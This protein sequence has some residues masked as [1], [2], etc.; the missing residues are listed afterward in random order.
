[1]QNEDLCFIDPRRND[2]FSSLKGLDLQELIVQ[3]ENFY[4]IYREKLNLP[5]YVTLGM[6]IEYEGVSKSQVDK[7]I[8]NNLPCWNS[9]I[10]GS[11]NSGGEIQSPVL[12]DEPKVWEDLQKI[13]EFLKENKADT[14]HNAGGHIHIGAHVLGDNPETW[15]KFLKLYIAYESVLFRFLYGDKISGRKKMLKYAEPMADKLFSRL[16]KIKSISS[17]HEMD[18][19]LPGDK[20]QAINFNHIAFWNINDS[21]RKNT[22]EYRCPNATD[23][24]VIWQNNANALSKMMLSAKLPTLDEEFLDYKLKHER[25]SSTGDFYMYNEVCLKNAL[26]FV[27][28][29]FDN[30]L[31]K[32]YFLRQYIKGFQDNYGMKEAVKSENFISRRRIR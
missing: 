2:T 24:E 8:R 15:K 16:N 22:I 7:F 4:L 12:H 31:D 18:W 29:V 30:N 5:K 23:E 14:L 11:L 3:I 1:M 19:H 25:I 9:S 20:Y 6:E 13:C 21:H 17:I 26:E 32:V 10:D 27:D 28:I